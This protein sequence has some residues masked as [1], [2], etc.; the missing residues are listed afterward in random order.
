MRSSRIVEVSARPIDIALHE[1][2]G[3]AGG[4]QAVA[5][6]VLVSLHLEDGTVGLG[7]AAP[8]PAVN[9]ETQ[10]Q[11]L[12]AVTS[13]AGALRGLDA[14]RLRL[15]A[16]R[17][18]ELISDSPSARAALES[19]ALDAICRSNGYSLWHF[20]G[21]SEPELVS[22][23]TIPTGTA[24]HAA[25]SAKRALA[26]GFTILKVKVGGVALEQDV[27]RLE[28]LARIAPDA[29]LVLDANGSMTSETAI[30]LLRAIGRTAR[31]VIL[32]EQP[33]PASDLSGL[34]T[35]R[36]TAQIAVAADESAQSAQDVAKLAL[37]G[38]CD[39]VNIK[40]MKTGIVEAVDMAATAR[41]H[42]LGLMIG[43]MVESKLAMTVSACLAAG[44]G[45]FR[46]VDLDTPLF[47]RDCPL[48]GGYE[49]VGARI[50]LEG[51]GPGHGVDV[52]RGR[53]AEI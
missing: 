31:R 27:G 53:G 47:M 16:A 43:G 46:F 17:L 49:Q 19:A 7:E 51:V 18:R 48:V 34:C 21:G 13:A 8:F 36:Q 38:A 6:N 37:A 2:F 3:I 39:V 20:F 30:Q 45:G 5:Q 9:G 22:D 50:R 12:Q 52:T 1:P 15:L 44:L 29:R 10:S 26:R 41:A 4:A 11:A 24:E 40:I 23:I 25:D 42:G 14:R 32:F 35:V 28:A 33:T